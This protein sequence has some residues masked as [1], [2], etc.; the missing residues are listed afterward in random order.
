[1]AVKAD[2]EQAAAETVAEPTGQ[3]VDIEARAFRMGWRPKDQYKGPEADWIPADQFVE[4]VTETL[5]VLKRTLKT[6]EERSERL[7]RKLAD[8]EQVLV[9][10]R[11]YATRA[12][13]RAYE[14]A[15]KELMA[16]RDVAIQHADIETVRSVET[17]IADL[18]KTAKP[19]APV[20]KRSAAE[21]DRAVAPDPAITEWV[22]ENSWFNSDSLLHGVAQ[23]IDVAIQTEKPGLPIRDRLAMVKEEVQR[24][25]PEKFG[26]PRREAASAVSGSNGVTPRRPAAKSYENLPAEAKKACDKI[27]AQFKGH[28]KPFTREEYVAN[29]D[30]GDQ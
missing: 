30:W 8:T 14:K 22:A 24:R 5:P 27:V 20:E 29:Y 12:D 23:S 11:E 16:Q 21:T 18:D 3:P 25:F 6:M 13:M 9:D 17:Q 28:K 1:M 26:N 15:K 4:R 10:F 7:E 19:S 2:A